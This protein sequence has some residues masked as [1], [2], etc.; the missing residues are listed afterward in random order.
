MVH[1]NL[2]IH[3]PGPSNTQRPF[4][5]TPTTR[6]TSQP[7]DSTKMCH[8]INL[9][10]NCACLVTS[11]TEKCKYGTWCS[12]QTSD[13]S[14]TSN[15]CPK[16]PD[17]PQLNRGKLGPNY[18]TRT[19]LATGKAGVEFYPHGVARRMEAEYQQEMDRIIEEAHL[20]EQA[21]S[22]EVGQPTEKVAESSQESESMPPT[23]TGRRRNSTRTKSRAGP[24]GH[25]RSPD[26]INC[27]GPPNVD[28]SARVDMEPEVFKHWL[29]SG[30]GR[31]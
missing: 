19:G 14:W 25:A 8:T 16:H 18:S 5:T 10:Y 6:S 1:H 22:T 30:R 29:R 27:W 28:T 7:S 17:Y 13:D 24:R 11:V 31:K 26:V 12:I 21:E 4:R 15:N 9:L 2:L 23:P 3:R 20:F